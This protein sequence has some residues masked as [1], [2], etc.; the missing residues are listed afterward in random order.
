MMSKDDIAAAKMLTEQLAEMDKR[1]E[2]EA[3]P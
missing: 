2:D 3:R 1:R